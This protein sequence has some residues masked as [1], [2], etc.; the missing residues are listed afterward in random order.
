MIEGFLSLARLF[1]L[2]PHPHERQKSANFFFRKTVLF[3]KNCNIFR[4][5]AFFKVNNC[6]QSEQKKIIDVPD[7]KR[8]DKIT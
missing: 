6:W 7:V 2:R 8:Y 1:S 5:V 3:Q 4:K